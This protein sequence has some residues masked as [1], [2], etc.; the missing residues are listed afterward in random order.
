MSYIHQRQSCGA[1][2]HDV[3][4]IYI[5]LTAPS[6]A[7]CAMVTSCRAIY[8]QIILLSTFTI[9]K[10]PTE[11]TGRLALI[12]RASQPPTTLFQRHTLSVRQYSRVYNTGVTSVTRVCSASATKKC[13]PRHG[14]ISKF[15]LPS[16]MS[17]AN[18]QPTQARHDHN[19]TDTRGS[20]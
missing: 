7:M 1:S 4:Y 11:N 13:W 6:H 2:N 16:S 10:V 8:G 18:R 20:L 3:R 19:A 12:Q 14:M 17:D 5:T 9:S 15:C